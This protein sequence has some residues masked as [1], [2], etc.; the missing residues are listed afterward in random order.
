MKIQFERALASI[1][2]AA[3][4]VVGLAVAWNSLR[5]I[6]EINNRSVVRSGDHIVFVVVASLAPSNEYVA[7]VERARDAF[8]DFAERCD[9]TF[10][11]VGISNHPDTGLGLEILSRYGSFDELAVGRSWFNSAQKR[12]VNDM[13]SVLHIPQVI[14]LFERVEVLDSDWLTHERVELGRFAGLQSLVEWDER[15][16]PI[17]IA[18]G[19][20]IPM[21]GANR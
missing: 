13:S 12:Y 15:G 21:L 11:T 14:G 6:D 16:A 18:K 8:R 3:L 5:P 19:R 9:C 10:S 2:L 7:A 4:L 20:A 17:D 1:W